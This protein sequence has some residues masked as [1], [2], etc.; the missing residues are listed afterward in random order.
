MVLNFIS[1]HFYDVPKA[2][3]RAWKNFLVFYWNFFSVPLLFRTLLSHWRKY[4]EPYGR[5]FDP[6]TYLSAFA[7][8]MISRGLGALV[9]IATI[10]SGL[11]VEFFVFVLGILVLA[12]WL[13][14]PFLL[15]LGILGGIN[16]FLI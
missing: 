11:I 16:L 12:L 9:R 1:W 3:L 8:N 7:S 4:I 14:F 13:L 6:K 2:I 10:I 5:G 15:I